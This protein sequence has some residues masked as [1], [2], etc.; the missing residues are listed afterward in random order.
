LLA[1]H[2][3]AQRRG[4]R[5]ERPTQRNEQVLVADI[6]VM[7]V[8]SPHLVPN[9]LSL[10]LEAPCRQDVRGLEKQRCRYPEEEGGVVRYVVLNLATV[11]VGEPEDS[12]KRHRWVVARG[13]HGCTRSLVAVLPRRVRVEDRK[14]P[15]GK[16]VGLSQLGEAVVS[17]LGA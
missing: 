11:P 17:H 5:L 6:V 12:F 10:V 9:E 1:N 13:R 14:L 15:V 4:L 16:R 3:K 2:R 7:A 8:D